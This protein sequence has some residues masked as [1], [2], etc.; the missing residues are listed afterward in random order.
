MAVHSQFQMDSCNFKEDDTKFA[1][2]KAL[3]NFINKIKSDIVRG[4]YLTCLNRI[5]ECIRS[6][7]I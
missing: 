4:H 3:L 5:Q 2:L 1:T 7:K 6:T